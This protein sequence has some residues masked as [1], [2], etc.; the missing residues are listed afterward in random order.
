MGLRVA[1]AGAENTTGAAG[2]WPRTVAHNQQL[3]NFNNFTIRKEC[4]AVYSQK[5]FICGS[6]MPAIAKLQLRIIILSILCG[7]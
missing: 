7:N 4:H 3:T 1:A 6:I 5:V 2:I